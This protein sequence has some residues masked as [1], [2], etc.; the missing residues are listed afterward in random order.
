MG[1]RMPGLKSFI[2]ARQ[3]NVK[4]QFNS[5]GIS[6]IEDPEGSDKMPERYSLSQNYPNPFN[7]ATTI[8]YRV[9]ESGIV[10]LKVY[11][12]RGNE[13]AE[14]VNGTKPAGT[15]SVIFD[16][17]SVAGRASSTGAV[18]S[19]VYIYKLTASEFRAVKKML[20]IK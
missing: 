9:P 2:T 20:F 7:P 6:G 4:T 12:L 5:L 8:Q 18:P 17:T 3:A 13:I 10:S 14:L 16:G 15:Y 19:G 1:Q 11:D